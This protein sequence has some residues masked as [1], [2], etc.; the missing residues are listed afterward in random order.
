MGWYL[1]V[2]RD[3]YFN[4]N[5]RA[6]RKEYWMF[7]LIHI[8]LLGVSMGLDNLLDTTFKS[9]SQNFFSDET[10]LVSQGIGYIYCLYVFALFLPGLGVTFR[11]LH[12][13]GRSGWFMLWCL[14]PLIGSIWFLIN[15]FKDS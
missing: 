11:R 6:R 12:D 5:G 8:I 9:E 4:F 1:R 2:V 3:N 15:M 10:I 7:T 14:L 13:I